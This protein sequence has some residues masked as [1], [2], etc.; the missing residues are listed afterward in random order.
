MAGALPNLVD[1]ALAV[2]SSN[3]NLLHAECE[4]LRTSQARQALASRVEL[5]ASP[6]RVRNLKDVEA[7]RK[8]GLTNAL[9]CQNRAFEALSLERRADEAA[10]R[11]RMHDAVI[12]A[13]YGLLPEQPAGMKI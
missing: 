9:R 10:A 4:R 1:S 8:A 3:E 12:C 13:K 2:H 6:Q 5:Q 11:Q 7:R